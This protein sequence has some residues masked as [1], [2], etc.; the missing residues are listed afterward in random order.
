MLKSITIEGFKSIKHEQVTLGALN[1]LIGANGSGKSNFMSAFRFLQQ[2]TSG[3]LQVYTGKQ[4]GAAN[5]FY[6]GLKRTRQLDFNLEFDQNK[7]H[8]SYLPSTNGSLIINDE[9]IFDENMGWIGPPQIPGRI[10]SAISLLASQFSSDTNWHG[11]T[12]AIF[13][14]LSS[15]RVYH[16]EDTSDTAAVKQPHDTHDNAYLRSDASNIAPFL[17]LLRETKYECY[18]RIVKTIRLVAPFFDDFQLRL[19]PFGGKT[20]RL[21]WTEKGADNRL[22]P[23]ALSDG[24]LR[25]ICLTT[26]LLQP[27]ET[28]PSTILIDEPELGLHPYAI[29]LLAGMLQS[30]ATE[31]QV[32]VSTQSVPLVNQF[33]AE[34][35]IV[36][37]REGGES[38][39]QR[40]NILDLEA[41]M[42]EYALGELW[43]KN[44][45][46]GRPSR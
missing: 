45:L 2:A 22:G 15:W 29:T 12:P 14:N 23:D 9:R 7:Y 44:L 21:E 3:N 24:T 42:G 31:R 30:I 25:F 11:V 10:E 4:G 18:N 40:L 33:S 8:A 19:D 35:L 37:N 13:D 32:I 6:F 38:K 28:L 41:W 34:D 26:L 20:I 16:F 39:F 36:V 17:Y 1:V 27:P 5:L 46:G 43:E